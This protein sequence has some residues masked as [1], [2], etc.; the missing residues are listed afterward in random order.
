MSELMSEYLTLKNK[1][2]GWFIYTLGRDDNED[3]DAMIDE[4]AFAAAGPDARLRSELERRGL[5]E[6]PPKLGKDLEELGEMENAVGSL[7]M[8]EEE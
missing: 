4:I 7:T 5:P 3:L 1:I 8:D 2:K 6:L